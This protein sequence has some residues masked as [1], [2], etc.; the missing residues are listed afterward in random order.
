[1]TTK[2][3]QQTFKVS[4]NIKGSLNVEIQADT[5]GQALEKAQELEFTDFAEVLGDANDYDTP[6]IF[7]IW[8]ID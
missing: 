8:A 5:W 6:E 1:M 4:A 3:T 2:K 7:S